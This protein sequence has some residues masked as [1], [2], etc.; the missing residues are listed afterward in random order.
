MDPPGSMTVAVARIN[1]D[2]G[3][4]MDTANNGAKTAKAP[5][6]TARRTM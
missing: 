4:G 2:T 5:K 3:S 6:A 1:A